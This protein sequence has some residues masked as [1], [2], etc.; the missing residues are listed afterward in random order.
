MELH[1]SLLSSVDVVIYTNLA[2]I[3]LL[4]VGGIGLR[5]EDIVNF[6][7]IADNTMRCTVEFTIFI[8]YYR[9]RKIAMVAH[10]F[11][12]F[13]LFRGYVKKAVKEKFEAYKYHQ[14]LKCLIFKKVD[15]C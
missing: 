4:F 8:S 3:V 15:Q 1:D 6:Y 12:R 10:V 7:Q 9:A 13:Q 2:Y 11:F 14:F 5:N